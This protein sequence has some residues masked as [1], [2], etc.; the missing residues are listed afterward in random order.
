[1]EF[2]VISVIVVFFIGMGIIFKD[3]VTHG[4]HNV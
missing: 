1:M 2:F 4:K 3:I